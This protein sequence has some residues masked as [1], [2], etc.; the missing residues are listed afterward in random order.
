[1][2]IGRILAEQFPWMLTAD[3]PV[4]RIG[5]ALG[6]LRRCE[7]LRRGQRCFCRLA[8]AEIAEDL[9]A[10]G[11]PELGEYLYSALEPEDV[12]E[13]SSR[14]DG[15]DLSSAADPDVAERLSTARSDLRRLVSAGSGL[16]DRYS[17]DL[18]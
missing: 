4:C 7:R 10:V 13:L 18:D 3:P 5:P 16:T 1:M 9:A 12:E 8:A 6:V 2:R 14:L 11:H 15:L 17:D